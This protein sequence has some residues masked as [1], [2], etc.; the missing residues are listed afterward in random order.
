MGAA[1]YGKK[2]KIYNKLRELVN[3]KQDGSFELDLN[4][5]NFYN[6][7]RPKYYNTKLI[8]HLGLKPNA[9]SWKLNDTY[10]DLAFA[11]QRV[12]E[13]IYLNMINGLYKKNKK[14]KNLVLSGGS[15][16]NSLAVLLFFF[17]FFLI[18][19]LFL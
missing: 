11:S 2:T 5:F 6:F 10:Y 19:S 3:L 13:E 18:D 16:L 4:Y 12:F 1:A 17:L 7:H 15:A 9:S 8:S 14:I